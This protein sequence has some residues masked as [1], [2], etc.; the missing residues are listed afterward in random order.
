VLIEELHVV[1]SDE[2]SLLD[3]AE[4]NPH[5]RRA[6]LEEMRSIEENGTW[7]LSELPP[8]RR[9]IG[10]KWGFKV[11]RDEQGRIVKHMSRLV[12]KGDAQRRG[13]DYDEVYVLVAQLDSIRL[14]IAL[15]AHQSRS[16]HHI[17]VKSIFL[18][19]DLMEEVYVEQP[20][21]I[22]SNN[23]HKVLRLRKTLYGLHQAPRAWNAKLNDTIFFWLLQVPF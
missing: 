4:Q 14:L 1:S 13:L 5:W 10:L 20:G 23:E 18:N 7:Y 9:A 22:N 8:G 15:A 17:G 12:V 16:I 21:F 11:K 3:E 6:M 2:P 19:G